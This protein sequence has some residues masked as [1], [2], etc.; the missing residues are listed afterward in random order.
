MTDTNPPA[1]RT[2]EIWT[3]LAAISPTMSVRVADG[4]STLIATTERS[5]RLGEFT[6]GVVGLVESLGDVKVSQ[7]GVTI[8]DDDEGQ[9]LTFLLHAPADIAYLLAELDKA[10]RRNELLTSAKNHATEARD[11]YARRVVEWR[12]AAERAA[13]ERDA[14]R[15]VVRDFNNRLE[16][17][18]ARVQ[19]LEG[20]LAKA[21]V[22]VDGWT[23]RAAN[24][25]EV[26][27]SS[28]AH[29]HGPSLL[30]SAETPVGAVLAFIADAEEPSDEH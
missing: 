20:Q 10:H 14:A 9:D 4:D 24:G 21:Q 23:M 25:V 17:K 22:D 28:D 1:D 2:A 30:T 29:P 5:E 26:L 18:E 13:A 16:R 19:E 6:N 15:D 11:K 8:A 3:R 12:E 27:I 7:T